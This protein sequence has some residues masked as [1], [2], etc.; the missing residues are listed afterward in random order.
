MRIAKSLLPFLPLGCLLLF[1]GKITAQTVAVSINGGTRYQTMDGFG[2]SGAF[3]SAYTL[4]H[5]SSSTE[6]RKVLDLLFNASSGAGLTILRNLAPSDLP[7]TIEPNS[8]GSPS[9]PP[10]Y[11]WDHD[12]WG[13]VWLAKQAQ[14]YGV[15]QFYLDAWSAPGFMKTNGTETNGGSLCGAPGTSCANDWRQAYANYLTQYLRD[16]QGDSVPITHIGAFNEP[17]IATSYS[18][19]QMSTSQATDFLK[20]LG[21]TVSS[22]GFSAQVT[23]CDPSAWSLVQAYLNSVNGDVS[24]SPILKVVS[25][26]AYDNNGL[27]STLSSVGSRHVWMSEWGGGSTWDPSW[28][29]GSRAS[30]FYIAYTLQTDLTAS[31]L[32]AYLYWQGV[33][34]NNTCNCILIQDNSGAITA[35]KRLW[36]MANFSRY[37]HPGASRIYAS[38]PTS[39]LLVTAYKNTDGTVA[40]VA[41]NQSLSTIWTS[42][43]QQNVGTAAAGTAVPYLTDATHNVS[44]EPGVLVENGRF[45]SLVQARGLVTFLITPGTDPAPGQFVDK[46]SGMCLGVPSGSTSPANLVQWNCNGSADQNWIRDPNDAIVSGGRTY[47]RW[48]DQISGLCLAVSGGSTA[49]GANVI[50]WPCYVGAD[51]HWAQVDLGSG[52][53]EML[54][55]GSNLCMGVASGSTSAGASIVQST[56]NG[57]ADQHW[58][59]T[60]P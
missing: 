44:P 50:Q 59:Y 37:I 30:G 22:S 42:F 56:C 25:G 55:Y 47:Y 35:T 31:N 21:P 16:Y 34:F 46:G 39:N 36:A 58:H 7:H 32:S 28:D 27:T 57:A 3:G 33:G 51:Q 20:I 54:N 38:S 26:H 43:A 13:Q 60:G 15:H 5:L 17:N 2:F 4:E 52:Y 6:Q 49:V 11:V 14:A 40:V 41:L 29:S 18:S 24:A 10:S 1:C 48:V 53:S 8:P 45:S 9:S 23:C 12:S 19:M